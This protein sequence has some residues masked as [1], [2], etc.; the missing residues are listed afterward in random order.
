VNCFDCA[1]NGRPPTPA[2]GI[3]I[4]CGAAVCAGCA[5]LEERPVPQPATVGNPLPDHTR[6]VVC[7]SCDAVLNHQHGTALTPTSVM[8]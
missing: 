7:V 8:S 6:A 5:R 4:S 2:V 3:C 1:I